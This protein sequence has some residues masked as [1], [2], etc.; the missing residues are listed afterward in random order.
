MFSDVEPRQNFN[1]RDQLRLKFFGRRMA[2]L[3]HAIDPIPHAQS[4][5]HWLK[6]NVGSSLLNRFREHD[7]KHADDRRFGAFF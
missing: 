2:L 4:I 6:V 1:T 7:I 3:Q 5:F